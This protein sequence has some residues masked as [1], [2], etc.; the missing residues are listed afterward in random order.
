MG[1]AGTVTS[2]VTVAV[3]VI[4]AIGGVSV[5]VGCGG[6]DGIGVGVAGCAMIGVLQAVSNMASIRMRIFFLISIPSEIQA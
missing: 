5:S 4:V 2:R 1:V 6:M 3:G